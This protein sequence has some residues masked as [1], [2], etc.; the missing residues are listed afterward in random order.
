MGKQ[1]CV[2]VK[3]TA[4]AGLS[5]AHAYALLG[6]PC[7]MLLLFKTGLFKCK[8]L[9]FWYMSDGMALASGFR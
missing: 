4:V 6:L 5:L 1:L 7:V 3:A 2:M 8:N 9:H